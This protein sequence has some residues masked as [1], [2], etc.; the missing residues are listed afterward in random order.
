MSLTNYILLPTAVEPGPEHLDNF[1]S[2]GGLVLG[3]PRSRMEKEQEKACVP[4][5]PAEVAVAAGILA[6]MTSAAPADLPPLVSV[7]P[8]SGKP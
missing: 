5:D 7:P 3:I 1:R 4:Y 6:G 2:A 8:G